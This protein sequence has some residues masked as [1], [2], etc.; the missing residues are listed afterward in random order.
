[1][2]VLNGLLTCLLAVAAGAAILASSTGASPVLERISFHDDFESGNLD[3][4][5]FPYPEDWAILP[6]KG[7]EKRAEQGS[8][9]GAQGVNRYLHMKRS[10]EPGVPRR[11]LQF[12]LLKKAK[13]GSFDFQARLRRQGKSMIVVFNYVDTLHFYYAHLSVDRG[14]QDAV[15]NGIF[16]VNGEPRRRIAGIDAPPALP[17]REWRHVRVTRDARAGTIQVFIDGAHEP[18]FSVVDDTFTCGQVGI[19]SFDET[20]DFDDVVLSSGDAGC[21]PGANLRPAKRGN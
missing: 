17:D 19:G 7:A 18:L 4:W 13:V 1:M 10:R 16:I 8:E 12:A 6:E 5:Q 21:Q 20:G 9:N 11:P 3:S 2:R 14:Q 15:H